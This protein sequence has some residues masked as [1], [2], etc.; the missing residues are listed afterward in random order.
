MSQVIRDPETETAVNKNYK[1][2]DTV[3]QAICSCCGPRLRSFALNWCWDITDAGLASLVE[4]CCSLR[5]LSLVGVNLIIGEA[6]VH[7]PI[8]QPS[9]IVLNL[10]QCNRVSDSVLAEV[11]EA[12]P[13]LYIFDY[14]GERVGGDMNDI[15]HYDVWRSFEKLVICDD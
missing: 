3:V 10:T 12:M 7:L 1:V 8:R 4:A 14:F 11:A 5:H 6:L 13:W 15:C 9:L 2:E